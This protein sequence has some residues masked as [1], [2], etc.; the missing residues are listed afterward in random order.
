MA[1]VIKS[2]GFGPAYWQPGAAAS[3]LPMGL[4]WNNASSFEINEVNTF[5][6]TLAIGASSS[7][8]KTRG[9]DYDISIVNNTDPTNVYLSNNTGTFS[10]AGSQ[11]FTVNF[12]TDSFLSHGLVIS[13]P[14]DSELF[15]KF[16][17]VS[18]GDSDPKRYTTLE[19]N[20]TVQPTAY[21]NV[22]AESL[23][24]ASMASYPNNFDTVTQETNKYAILMKIVRTNATAPVI[25]VTNYRVFIITF[26]PLIDIE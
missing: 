1:N 5:A 13:Q 25:N 22:L 2:P 19:R 18:A 20:S 14:S 11:N 8:I 26:A 12:K 17:P 3:A 23:S 6:V 24:S 10:T 9:W 16:G 4:V 7:G 21:R 15:S